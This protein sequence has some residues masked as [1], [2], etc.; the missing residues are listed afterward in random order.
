MSEIVHLKYG[1][2][3]LPTGSTTNTLFSTVTAFPGARMHMQA[4]YNW[5]LGK[6]TNDKK[7][8]LKGYRS[9]DATNGVARGT[10]WEQ[11]YSRGICPSF[12]DYANEFAIHVGMYEDFKI[13]WVN[14]GTTQT[15][16]N[17]DL[18]LLEG[19]HNPLATQPD[20]SFTYL[21]SGDMSAAGT[22]Q[23]PWI[24]TTGFK[25]CSIMLMIGAVAANGTFSFAGTDD[26]TL[27]TQVTLVTPTTIHGNGN[28]LVY[29]SSSAST[30][31]CIFENLPNFMAVVYARTSGG[32]A[33]QLNARVGLEVN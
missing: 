26:P 17:P 22:T 19:E 32:G 24:D 5:F 28:S 9:L 12:T 7:G 10:N 21:S 33:T 8:Q 31:E 16:F 29:N 20:R 1:G 13:D 6:L 4:G 2:T 3:A 18:I 23:Y 11:V 15:T 27:A 30:I 25:T 14:G